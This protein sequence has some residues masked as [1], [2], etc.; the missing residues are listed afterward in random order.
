MAMPK[1]VIEQ[2]VPGA[3]QMDEATLAANEDVIREHGRRGGFPI[4]PAT[5]ESVA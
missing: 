5:A 1:Y 2:S 4:N 3:G